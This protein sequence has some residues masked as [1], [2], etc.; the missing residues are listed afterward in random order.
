MADGTILASLVTLLG[1]LAVKRPVSGCSHDVEMPL[2][3]ICSIQEHSQDRA[4]PQDQ[5]Q[6]ICNS[7]ATSSV[8][9]LESPQRVPS[10]AGVLPDEPGAVFVLEPASLPRLGSSRICSDTCT[11][12]QSAAVLSAYG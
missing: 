8:D 2:I 3:C 7:P 1:P 12:S 5:P 4:Q 9:A 11:R 6:P 10:S